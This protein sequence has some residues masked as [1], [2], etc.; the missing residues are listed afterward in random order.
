MAGKRTS[1]I[2]GREY[3]VLKLIWGHGPL[4]IREIR[5]H[6]TKDEEIPYT[7]V[8]SLIQLMERKGY[9]RHTAEGATYRYTARKTQRVMT[10]LLLRDF[11]GRFFEGSSEALVMGLAESEDVEPEVLEQLQDELRKQREKRND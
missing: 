9:L 5:A 2:S 7:S 10:R 4:T 6:L 8:L 1:V 11:M 3:A